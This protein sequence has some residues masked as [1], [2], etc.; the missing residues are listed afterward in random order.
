MTNYSTQN[1]Y[2]LWSTRKLLGVFRDTRPEDWYFDQFF[3]NVL[4]STDE[5]IDFEKLPVRNRQLAQFVKPMGQGHG[6]F[7][8]K[9]TGY[10]FKPANIVVQD[11]VDPLRNLTIQPGIDPSMLHADMAQLN[12]KQRLMLIK[13]EMMN[14]MLLSVR[15]RWEWMR[16]RAIV[17]GKV[18]VDYLDG[19]SVL[20][21][22]QRASGHTVTL[23][24]G[25]KWGDSGVSIFDSIQTVIDTMVNA[26]FGALPR[27]IT[28]GGALAKIVRKDQEILQH[29]DINIRNPVITVDRGPVAG[30]G[31]RGNGKVYKFGELLLGG[32]SGVSIEL[33]QNDE[34]Y[35]VKD[36]TTGAITQTRYIGATDAVFTGDAES[37]KGYSCFGMIVDKDAQY[38]AI[39]VFPKNYESVTSNGRIKVEGVSA[40]SAPL[41]VPINPNA[42]YLLHAA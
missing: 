9:V 37:I 20:V 10:R 32:A 34:T 41:F 27:K 17:D 31:V 16:C 23:S 38:Q 4:L 26:Q 19:T 15:R 11:E 29:M 21:D 7:S 33:W 18:Q 42:T 2:E 1:P 3:T 39:P 5:W 13:A 12:P 40:E 24:S 22:F 25:N 14:E 8:D 36:P 6:V 35:D 30:P 28:M